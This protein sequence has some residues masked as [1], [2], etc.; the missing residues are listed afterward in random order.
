MLSNGELIPSSP[1]K[2]LRA[3]KG[4]LLRLKGTL[5]DAVIEVLKK[6]PK[7]LRDTVREVTLDMAA[8]MKRSAAAADCKT[9]FCQGRSDN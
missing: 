4:L 3:E 5:Q 7:R 8:N 6:I 1:I 2:R 9:L